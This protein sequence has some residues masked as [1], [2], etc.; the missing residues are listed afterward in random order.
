MFPEEREKKLEPT[1]TFY[2]V[3][4]SFIKEGTLQNNTLNKKE[5]QNML[6]GSDVAVEFQRLLEV[7]RISFVKWIHLFSKLIPIENRNNP[8]N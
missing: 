3:L 8:T 7:K 5:I 6:A 1:T 2:R 4:Q